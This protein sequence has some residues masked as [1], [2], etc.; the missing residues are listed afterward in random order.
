M[1]PGPYFAISFAHC[2]PGHYVQLEDPEVQARVVSA[3]S[4]RIRPKP[5]EKVSLKPTRVPEQAFR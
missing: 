5:N 2:R 4:Q 1:P 3:Y